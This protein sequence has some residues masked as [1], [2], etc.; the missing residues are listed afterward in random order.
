MT[1][2][3]R[4]YEQFPESAQ[5]TLREYVT[6]GRPMGDFL[7]AVAS[8]DLFNAVGRADETNRPL[9]PRYVQWFY[10]RAPVGSWGSP[11]LVKKWLA[12]KGL[13]GAPN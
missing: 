5:E 7:T 10:N 4:E 12:H 3:F 2:E 1:F 6:N 8:N 13:S 9:I 11:E